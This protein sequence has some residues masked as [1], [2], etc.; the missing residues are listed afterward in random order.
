VFDRAALPSGSHVN[1]PAIV[2]EFGSTTA[3]F[4]GQ[5][6]EVDPHGILVIRSLPSEASR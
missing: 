4:P 5:T 2:E 6:V 1:G 3:V